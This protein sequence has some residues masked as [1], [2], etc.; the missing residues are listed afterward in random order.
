MVDFDAG[1]LDG[2]GAADCGEA[3]RRLYHYLDGELT[4]ERRAVI[5]RHLD[6]CH[7][8]IEAYEFEVELRVAIS[9]GCQ[10]TVPQALIDRVA[11]A[12]RNEHGGSPYSGL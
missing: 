4:V 2:T 10:E 9:R 11:E 12:I 5:R 3:V 8:C 6:S 7:D 1:G